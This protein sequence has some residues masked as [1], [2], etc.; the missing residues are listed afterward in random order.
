MT[1]AT[2]PPPPPHTPCAAR[3]GDGPGVH[4]KPIGRLVVSRAWMFLG[5]PR[6]PS[7]PLDAPRTTLADTSS[8]GWQ[9]RRAFLLAAP[10]NI[11]SDA[12]SWRRP[13]PR[14]L[15]VTCRGRV[16]GCGESTPSG[17]N[18]APIAGCGCCATSRYTTSAAGARREGRAGRARSDTPRVFARR[19]EHE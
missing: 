7:A 8:V 10:S 1:V 14:G 5:A 12:S 4:L 19:A 17:C 3:R 9:G 16:G 6:R 18:P 13:E 11:Q 2:P 15:A